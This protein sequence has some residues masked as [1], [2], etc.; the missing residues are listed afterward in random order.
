MEDLMGKYFSTGLESREEFKGLCL[1]QYQINFTVIQ[2]CWTNEAKNYLDWAL[3]YFRIKRQHH[4][5]CQLPALTF[6]DGVQ[7]EVLLYP[8]LFFFPPKDELEKSQN[9]ELLRKF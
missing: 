9:E 3:T 5:S 7:R 1:Y 8:G 2:A 4:K 6:K